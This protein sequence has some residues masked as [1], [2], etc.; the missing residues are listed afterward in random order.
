MPEESKKEESKKEETE[1]VKKIIND[2]YASV[3]DNDGQ[4][5]NCGNYKITVFIT[6][7]VKLTE[8]AMI[9]QVFKLDYNK[10]VTRIVLQD[11]LYSIG[12]QGYIEVDNSAS[13]LDK[14]LNRINQVYVVINITEYV[15]VDGKTKPFIKYEPYIFDISYVENVSSPD[16]KYKTLRLGL[17]DCMTS[18]LEQHSIGSVIQF[19]RR[20]TTATSYKRVFQ[21]IHAYVKDHIN[22]NLNNKFEWKKDLLYN[23]T[24]TF[25]KGNT[26]GNDENT[27]MSQLVSDTFSRIPRNATI[28]E[29][30]RTI[31][32][33][34][35]TTMFAPQRFD[36]VYQSIGNVLIPFY[37]KEEYPDRYFLY[38]NLWKNGVP[39]ES[40]ES[41]VSSNPP[42]VTTTPDGTVATS[43]AS[44]TGTS[45][46]TNVGTTTTNGATVS[47]VGG[48]TGA[49]TQAVVQNDTKGKTE[50]STSGEQKSKENEE[51]KKKTWSEE[52]KETINKFDKKAS[53][54][55]VLFNKDYSSNK[56]VEYLL[57]RQ[58]TMRDLYMPFLMAFGIDNYGCIFETI[59]PSKENQKD[60]YM[61]EESSENSGTVSINGEVYTDLYNVQYDPVRIN[62]LKKLWKNVVFIACNGTDT[63]GDSTLIFFSWFYDYFTNVFLNESIDEGVVRKKFACACPAFH[64]MMI[65]EGIPHGVATTAA[66]K[67]KG[68]I[69]KVDEHNSYIYSTRTKDTVKECMRL[70]GKNIAS[71]VLAN[72]S[73]T[74][75]LQGNLRRRPNEIIKFCFTPNSDDGSMRAI[76]ISTGIFDVNRIYL[77][78]SSVTHEFS[79]NNY[80]NT[81]KT[82]KFMEE[83]DDGYGAKQQK[84]D[85]YKK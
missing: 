84:K 30:L 38:P 34:A 16:E 67:D 40:N 46:D 68:F 10:Q 65:N 52:L 27:Y 72:D 12:L 64:K 18:V 29:A 60:N 5:A 81:I 21:F 19:D 63:A 73:Y 77:Y 62:E 69:N 54:G 80:I 78:V 49:T 3:D 76:Q 53:D 41:Q 70:M 33:D 17:M 66:D 44:N 55:L 42:V 61:V 82:H 25:V 8:E 57:Y 58:M 15:T 39:S 24:C 48:A 9:K 26:S 7:K 43:D 6:P 20:I 85:V 47:T 1:K 74:F 4:S 23:D 71:F 36:D 37:F 51:K 56:E 31:Y 45:V 50:Q 22:T 83:Y 28:A 32:K 2:L 35:C 13:W 59:S 79:G 14:V 11:T 75:S